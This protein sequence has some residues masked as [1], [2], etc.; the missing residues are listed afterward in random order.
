MKFNEET[1]QTALMWTRNSRP[2]TCLYVIG[3]TYLFILL[4]SNAFFLFKPPNSLLLPSFGS[5]PKHPKN[6]CAIPKC[7]SPASHKELPTFPVCEVIWG[8]SRTY[9]LMRCL[10]PPG[11]GVKALLGQPWELQG[12]GVVSLG[13]LSGSVSSLCVSVLL[14]VWGMSC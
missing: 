11:H 14:H 12:P 2:A 8:T 4:F 10:S 1:G 7:S 9:W 6:S 5:S 13:R 3:P